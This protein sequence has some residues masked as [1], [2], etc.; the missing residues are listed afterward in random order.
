[1]MS[2]RIDNAHTTGSVGISY[3][4][5]VS[6]I[7]GKLPSWIVRWGITVVAVIFSGIILGCCLIKYPQTV[8]ATVTITTLSPPADL[9][10]R[11][12][13]KLERIFVRDKEHVIKGQVIALIQNTADF[14]DVSMVYDSLQ[15]NTI[16]RFEV[17]VTGDWLQG[18]YNL[19]DL[20][21]T[22]E[23]FRLLCL[24]YKHYLRA[25]NISRKKSLLTSQ[26]SKN[27][28]YR[29]QLADRNK[30]IR[31]DMKYEYENEQRYAELYKKG[32]ISKSDY[33]EAVRS[34]LQTEQNRK[35]ADATLTSSDIDIMQME[36]QIIEL[37]MQHDDEV[38]AYERQ[39]NQYRQ[40]LLTAIEQ[41]KYQYVI[42]SPIN[43]VVTFVK[44]WNKNQ[45]VT[46]GDRIAS[47]VPI[48]KSNV[49]GRLSV[50]SNSFGKVKVGQVVNVKLNGYPYMEYGMLKGKIKSI[51]SVPDD[52]KGYIVEVIFPQG[53]ITT[54][55]KELRMI[56]KMDGIAQIVTEDRR[57]IGRFVDPIRE[58]FER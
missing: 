54:Y 23:S 56:Q 19:G 50:P 29:G 14:K 41:W 40:Q 5:E 9:I 33:E 27:K 28:K 1:M 20:Q 4:D 39:L 44:Y 51:S 3:S 7:M 8:D 53:L 43:G 16:K 10:A 34:R 42:E 47:V 45:Q 58:L 37:D 24:D 32:L 18:N 2:D 11:S 15:A 46:K 31:E 25:D 35:G 17:F 12:E 52:D 26:I 49:I 22:Y 36:Q 6:D 13:G 30:L 55:K 38:T 21:Q 57:L 48:K